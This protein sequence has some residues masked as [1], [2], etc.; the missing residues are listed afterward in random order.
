MVEL[1]FWHCWSGGNAELLDSIVAAFNESQD[2]IH[3]TATYQGDYWEAASKAVLPDMMEKRAGKI[4]NICS[5]MSELGRETVSE[6]KSAVFCP[7]SA[8]SF[9]TDAT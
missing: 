8:T 1:S 3:V 7:M 9:S 4:I 6:K 5:M 2:K